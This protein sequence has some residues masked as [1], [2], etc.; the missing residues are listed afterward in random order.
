MRYLDAAAWIQA[1]ARTAVE[2]LRDLLEEREELLARYTELVGRTAYDAGN[3]LQAVW[4]AKWSKK[5][6]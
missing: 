2:Y 5:I 6:T 1:D 3:D 4:N